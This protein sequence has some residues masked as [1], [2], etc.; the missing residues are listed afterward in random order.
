MAKSWT[1]D[2]DRGFGGRIDKGYFVK[3]PDVSPDQR[4]ESSRR[5]NAY[6]RDSDDNRVWM[7]VNDINANFAMSGSTAQS[8]KLRS[9]FPH[10]FAQPSI[11]LS[12]Q[13]PN[14][15]QYNRL[16]E[17]VR[18]CHAQSVLNSN[19]NTIR[20]VV[21]AGGEETKRPIVRGHRNSIYLDG[22]I[23]NMP[24]RAER[25]I[26]APEFQFEF[27]I[28]KANKFLG[29]NDQAINRIKIESIID[30]ITDPQSGYVFEEGGALPGTPGHKD[31]DKK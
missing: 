31:K 22:Y 28:T 12:G 19:E 16:A 8:K 4:G 5:S 20:L 17:F 27:I 15:Y 6:L 10:N 9:Y 24:R 21:L 13:T 30:V 11:T 18:K 7:W 3:S 29:L 25:F 14:Q 1:P 2:A 26:N 23:S